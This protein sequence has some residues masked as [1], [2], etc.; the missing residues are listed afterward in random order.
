MGAIGFG[1]FGFASV[2][3]YAGFKNKNLPC[4]I[5]SALTGNAKDCTNP[6]SGI[7][8]LGEAL[9]ALAALWGA[10]K[11]AGALGGAAGAAAGAGAGAAASK[12]GVLATR[13]PQ[14]AIAP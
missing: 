9:T 2:L 7:Q 3:V 1:I 14:A 8:T 10:S 11:V 5:N 13:I 6:S 12:G 4:L